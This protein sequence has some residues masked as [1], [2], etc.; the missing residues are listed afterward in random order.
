MTAH[1]RFFYMT[2]LIIP[3]LVSL[4]APQTAVASQMEKNY[5]TKVLNLMEGD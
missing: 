3:L 1:Q 4:F 2:L 5:I